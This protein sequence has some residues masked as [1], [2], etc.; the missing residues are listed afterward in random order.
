MII[1]LGQIHNYPVGCSLCWFAVYRGCHLDTS[2]NSLVWVLRKQWLWWWNFTC[3][4]GTEIL[5]ATKFIFQVR[6]CMA[7][8]CCLS[9]SL[10]IWSPT[11]FWPYQN[12][13]TWFVVQLIT[14]I[15][16]FWQTDLYKEDWIGLQTLDKAGKLSFV[17]LPGNHLSISETEMED[18]IVP[19]LVAPSESSRV[20]W[21]DS[22]H[23]N[24]LMD[25]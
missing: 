17:A 11:S 14:I 1:H 3:K 10:P 15:L 7:L 8:F 22:F 4:W 25:F 21:M 5:N 18:H 23:S 6:I 13:N 20:T 9:Q 16:C 2:S 19:F 12:Y 24:A